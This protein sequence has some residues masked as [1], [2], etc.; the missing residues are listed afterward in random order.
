MGVPKQEVYWSDQENNNTWTAS[1][2]NQAGQ[3]H[4]KPQDK[5]SALKKSGWYFNSYNRRCSCNSIHW[6]TFIHKIQKVG[7][8]WGYFKSSLCVFRRRIVWMSELGFFKYSGGQVQELPCEVS[9][10]VF[11]NLNT[12]QQSKCCA[13]TNASFNEVLFFTLHQMHRK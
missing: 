1:A 7:S 5:L 11:S 6:T 8:I 4:C 3:L 2:T 13:V 9:D 12:S 10:F